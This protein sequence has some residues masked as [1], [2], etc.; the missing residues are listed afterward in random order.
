M[1]DRNGLGI[2]GYIFGSVTVA[3]VLTAFVIVLGHI[4]G[5]LALNT[6]PNYSVTQQ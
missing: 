4:N 6:S 5:S 3:V 2:L 1:A